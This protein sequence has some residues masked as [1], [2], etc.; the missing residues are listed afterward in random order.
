MFF[1]MMLIVIAITCFI[2]YKEGYINYKCSDATWHT[3][4]TLKAY[5]DTPIREHKFL[6]IVSLGD[7]DDK[8]IPWGL[9]VPDSKGNYYYTSFSPGGYILPYIF[10]KIFNLPISEESLYIFST[11][12][13]IVSTFLWGLLLHDIYIKSK[14]VLI[15]MLIGMLTYVFSPE[16]LHGMGM[17][18]WHQSLMQVTLLIQIFAYYKMKN[19]DSKLSKIIFYSLSLIN[20]YIEWTGYVANVGFGL[21]EFIYYFKTDKRKAFLKAFIL[22]LITL[23]SFCLFSFHYLT[24]LDKTLFFNALM[25]RFMSRNISS[26]VP[27]ISVFSGYLDSFLYLWILLLI[28]IVWNFLK[29]KKITLRFGL[30]FLVLF[31]PILE[32]FIMSQHAV[33]YTYDRMKLIF[34]ISFMVCELSYNLL[35][36][37]KSNLYLKIILISIVVIS[38]FFNYKSY[39]N[40]SSFV[41]DAPQRYTNEKFVKYI[42]KN[43]DNYILGSDTRVRGYVNML[44]EKGVYEFTNINYLTKIGKEKSKDYVILL[45]FSIEPWN[46]DRIDNVLIY[47]IKDDK[48]Y[49]LNLCHDKVCLVDE[50]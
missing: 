12:L 41:W 3:I 20:P 33:Q 22:G 8:N 26:G 49:I 29:N 38:C 14:N 39:V 32:N 46:I 47:S 10:V 43:Y 6:P 44:F 31:F 30:L 13:L 24:V 23:L 11:I 21:A 1:S 34:V 9:T 4:L 25:N 2:K 40:D 28:L 42:N 17:V 48:N 18:Y 16:I 50:S 19:N 7:K 15:I 35:N 36:K 37:K 27:L 45:K 5:E